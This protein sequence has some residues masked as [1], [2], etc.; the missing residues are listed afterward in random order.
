MKNK[1]ILRNLF[2]FAIIMGCIVACTDDD[3][4]VNLLDNNR[5]SL[6]LTPSAYEVELIEDTP[7]E[8]ALRLDW[9]EADPV[10]S[11]YLISYLYKM[12]LENNAFGAATQIREYIDDDF[13]KSYTHKE[14]QNLLVN[15]WGQQ[16]GDL[17]TLQMR[18]I[19]TLEGPKFVKPEVSTISVKVKMYSEKAFLADHLYMSGSA[20]GDEDI[21]IFP[22]ESR[23]KRYL[24]ICELKAGNIRFPI[25]LKDDNKVNA[26]S[27]VAALQ[28]IIEGE[29]EAKNKFVENA[30][31]WAIPEDG[32]YRVVVDFETR[33]VSI[34]LADNYVEADKVYISGTCVINPVEMIRTVEDENQ[35][36]FHGELQA[37]TIYLPILFNGEQTTAISPNESGDFADGEEMAITTHLT[38]TAALG[39]HWNITTAGVYRVVVNTQTKKIRIYSPATDPKP[40]HLH[41]DF[42]GS[43]EG[44]IETIYIWGPYNGWKADPDKGALGWD[45]GYSREFSMKASVANPY[46]FIYKGAALPR[47]SKTDN[48]VDGLAHSG[49]MNFK[50]DPHSGGAYSY[51]S[52]G[53]AKRGV[54]NDVIDV[55]S[56]QLG[57]KFKVVEGQG[58]NRYNFFAIPEGVNYIELDTK[59]LTVIFGKR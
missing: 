18:V 31:Y 40:L 35:Y 8:I 2:F 12:D 29:M 49:A 15:K 26:I 45:N 3:D 39:L 50:I 32:T 22:M 27:P 23:P 34:G 37:G 52:D 42:N 56:S 11:E 30:G 33:T 19:G 54:K 10:G 13:Y 7:D 9:T 25:V 55:T 59:N 57:Q 36:A 43:K 20:V 14:L 21:E 41:W 48:Y 5:S 16:P 53:K 6:V 58:D 1:N 38:S 28:P 4:K 24:A 46:L 51:G 17:V 44:D 47:Q